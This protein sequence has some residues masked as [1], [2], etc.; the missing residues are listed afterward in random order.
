ME[1][2]L[3]E[4]GELIR[5]PPLEESGKPSMEPR[6]LERGEKAPKLKGA[7]VQYLQWSRAC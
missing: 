1:P 7:V 6:L 5:P 3:L 4:R 2:R